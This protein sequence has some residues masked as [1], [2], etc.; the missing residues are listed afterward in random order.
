MHLSGQLRFHSPYS[1]DN[2]D[3]AELR[4]PSAATIDA[5]AAYAVGRFT[6]FAYAHNLLDSLHLLYRYDANYAELENPRV[7]GIG[8][9]ARF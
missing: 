8:I 1:S 2:F 4:V 9:G 3:T 6:L 5:R 7:V